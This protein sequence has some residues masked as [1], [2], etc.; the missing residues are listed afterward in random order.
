MNPGTL[1][2]TKAN[3]LVTDGEREFHHVLRRVVGE[4]WAIHPKVR[5]EDIAGVPEGTPGRYKY[6]NYVRSSH[7]DFLL[8]TAD[9]A[10]PVLA[11]ELDDSSHV[12]PSAQRRD[13]LKDSILSSAGLPL[14][15]V[16][17]QPSYDEHRLASAINDKVPALAHPTPTYTPDRTTYVPPPWINSPG[18]YN[19]RLS[20]PRVN[21]QLIKAS[22][23][24]VVSI[25]L[26]YGAFTGGL[27]G[28]VRSALTSLVPARSATPVSQAPASVATPLLPA[29]DTVPGSALP[30]VTVTVDTAGLNL[31]SG[32]GTNYP[33]VTTYPKGTQ[34]Q[35]L[36]KDSTATWLQVRHPM[37]TTGW[38][39][40]RFLK[41]SVPLDNVPVVPDPA[42]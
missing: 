25:V 33:P 39:S 22:F 34:L 1:P 10:S 23:L 35:A 3:S 36:G 2:Y 37:G 15:R 17:W 12:T 7:V 8:C 28:I 38:M 21:F 5:L 40:V 30:G 20:R 4:R 26:L 24:L 41:L 29:A 42:P 19:R 32:P 14:L 9:T 31:R 11:I 18:K 27:N 16:P 13:A 6:R